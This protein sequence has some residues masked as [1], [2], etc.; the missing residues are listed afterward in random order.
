MVIPGS[1]PESLEGLP[2]SWVIYRMK[3]TIE[4]GV[5]QQNHI[6][7]KQ[8]R[9][10]RSLDPTALELAHTM[11]WATNRKKNQA[12]DSQSVENLWPDKLQYSLSTPMK[13]VIFGSNICVNFKLIPLLKGL[14]IG[15]ITT[16]LVE[17]Q[18][19]NIRGPKVMT[20]SRQVVR[21]ICKDE[22]N[23]PDETPVD[24]IEG[25]EGFQFSRSLPV[26]HSLKRC[27]QTA[28]LTGIKVRHSLMFNVQ[29]NNPDGHISEVSCV[30]HIEYTS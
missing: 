27:V 20:R 4:R 18:D 5:L 28:D 7:R 6:A 2:D 17:K 14:K 1:T 8:V 13:A 30:R 12:N 29:L 26:P 23:I 11:V 3:A 19:L 15:P 16:E 21:K 25:Q 22:Y 24:D 9:I 10:V